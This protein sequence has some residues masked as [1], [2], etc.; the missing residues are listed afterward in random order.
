MLEARTYE[1]GGSIAALG[2]VALHT[3]IHSHTNTE[4]RG[5]YKGGVHTASPPPPPP[6]HHARATSV[7]KAVA[8]ARSTVWLPPPL[9]MWV[10]ADQ[11]SSRQPWMQE[12]YSSWVTSPSPSLSIKPNRRS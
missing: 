5:M 11:G 6:S 2:I 12:E 3:I 9:A 7:T 10:R 1:G 4:G 8:L